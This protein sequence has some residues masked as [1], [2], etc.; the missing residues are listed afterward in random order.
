MQCDHSLE[1]YST[2]LSRGAVCFVIHCGSNFLLGGSNH[3][4]IVTI[5]AL[6]SYCTVLS[7]GQ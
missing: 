7:C 3:V 5:Q 1:S 6:E 2:V 4:R